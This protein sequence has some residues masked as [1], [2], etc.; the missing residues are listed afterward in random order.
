M[1]QGPLAFVAQ[2]FS[3]AFSPGR[4]DP[5]RALY[6]TS[7]H[8]KYYAGVYGTPTIGVAPATV[9]PAKAGASFRGANQSG[10][11]LS[12]A[13]AATYTGLCL[14][15]PAASTVNLSVKKI[16]GVITNAVSG[17]LGLGLIAGWSAAG[18]TVHT[19]PINTA[20]LN[21]YIGA[22]TAS[23]SVLGPASQANLDA[24]C[25]LVGTPAWVDWL[26]AN[27]A[28]NSDLSFYVDLD[29]SLLIPPGGYVAIGAT[30]AQGGFFGSFL[31]EELAP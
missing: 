12:A 28:A 14:S 18:V 17:Q 10:A 1:G 24:A 2:A 6:S 23:G 4:I 15:N 26:A 22:A 20:I 29:E 7:R 3:G 11:T 5:Q 8:G 9:T 25:T 16:G 27:S 31:W 19:T 13:L 30:A 21:S